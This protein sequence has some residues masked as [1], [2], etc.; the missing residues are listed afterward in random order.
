MIKTSQDNDMI[1]CKGAIYTED[2]I[3]L[4]WSI[5]SGT[6]CDKN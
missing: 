5:G 3:E 1:D 4:S 6:V 2:E